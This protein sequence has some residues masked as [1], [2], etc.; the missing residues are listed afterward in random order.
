MGVLPSFLE[1]Q[2]GRTTLIDTQQSEAG[3]TRSSEM[4][5]KEPL[6]LLLTRVVLILDLEASYRERRKFFP[7]VPEGQM[8][9]QQDEQK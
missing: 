5:G 9:Y 1:V 7:K 3:R 4:K 6:H 8:T 2:Q